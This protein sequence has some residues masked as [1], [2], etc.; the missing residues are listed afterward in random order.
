MNRIYVKIQRNL[1]LR[2]STNNPMQSRVKKALKF[3]L[4]MNL[5]I[6]HFIGQKD[7]EMVLI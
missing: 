5:Y 2:D 4:T 1:Q 3:C 6:P 7:L